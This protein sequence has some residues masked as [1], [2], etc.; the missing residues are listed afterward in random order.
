MQYKWM[1]HHHPFLAAPERRWVLFLEISAVLG[2]FEVLHCQQCAWL[3]S[4]TA[5]K[6]CRSRDQQALEPPG[7]LPSMGWEGFR[8]PPA[9][10]TASAAPAWQAPS[11]CNHPLSLQVLQDQT[12]SWSWDCCKLTKFDTSRTCRQGCRFVLSLST[13][14]LSF[15]ELWRALSTSPL[16]LSGVGL[17]LRSTCSSWNTGAVCIQHEPTQFFYRSDFNY[18]D[19]LNS[20][21]LWC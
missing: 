14:K 12:E 10:L 4:C 19:T 8:D 11:S 7:L 3:G 16:W 6:P 2:V 15:A 13:V 21:R 17:L 20:S 9:L 5:Y 18:F 1:C